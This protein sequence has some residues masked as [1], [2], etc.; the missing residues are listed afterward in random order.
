MCKA[1]LKMKTCY[2]IVFLCLIYIGGAHADIY[3]CAD[4]NG[5]A[6]FCN[7]QIVGGIRVLTTPTSTSQEYNPVVSR[8]DVTVDDVTGDFRDAYWADYY[9]DYSTAFQIYRKAA[10][11]GDGKGQFNLGV[12]YLTG[13]HGVPRDAEEAMK[14][15]LLAA[16]QGDYYAIK[17]LI[18]IYGT[19]IEGVPMNLEEARKWKEREDLKVGTDDSYHPGEASEINYTLQYIDTPSQDGKVVVNRLRNAAKHG[20]LKAQLSLGDIL[21]SGIAVRGGFDWM[22]GQTTGDIYAHKV[23]KEALNWYLLAANQGSAAAKNEVGIIYKNGFGIPQ[24]YTEAVKWLRLASQQ[25]HTS[26]QFVLAE[27]YQN[28]QGVLKNNV[29]AHMWFNIGTALGNIGAAKYRDNIEKLMSQQQVAE[30][31]KM[32]KDCLANNYK[33]CD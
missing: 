33:G 8:I 9:G 24:D 31:Q 26:A 5:E 7:E 10:K 19:G 29:R 11:K 13:R 2:L 16:Q 12:M 15:F 22:S 6:F 25:G 23:Y 20:L 17:N 14:W 1:I 18:A 21:S 30:A 32:A 4:V 3:R 27:M 28:G